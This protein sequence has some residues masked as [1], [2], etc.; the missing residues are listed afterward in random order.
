[1]KRV[2]SAHYVRFV[3]GCLGKPRRSHRN[4]ALLEEQPREA[5]PNQTACT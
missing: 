1:M 5:A 4:V 2:G 3:G